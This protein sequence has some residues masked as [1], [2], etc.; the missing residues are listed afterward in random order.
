MLDN[1]FYILM[2]LPMLLF[3]NIPFHQTGI[4]YFTGQWFLSAMFVGTFIVY[5]LLIYKGDLYVKILSPIIS[6]LIYG[7]MIWR[8][9]TLI[10]INLKSDFIDG[11]VLRAIAGLS[12]GV[13]AYYVTQKISKCKFNNLYL[14]IIKNIFW[15]IVI[16]HTIYSNSKYRMSIIVLLFF[17]ICISFASNH[18]IKSNTATNHIAKLSMIMFIC[19]SNVINIFHHLNI[20]YENE[21]LFVAIIVA[22]VIILSEFYYFI[23]K[24]ITN[25]HRSVF[26]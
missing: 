6:I 3:I 13:F 5:S 16:W 2:D 26:L 4:I 22:F 17:S 25:H 9:K 24:T 19:H 18:T 15:V 20:V 11:G 1:L 14:A 8:Y 7:Y 21:R 23:V 10:N 12:L